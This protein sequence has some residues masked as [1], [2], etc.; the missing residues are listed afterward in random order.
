[1]SAL[2]REWKFCGLIPFEKS[3]M[4]IVLSK[5]L[6]AKKF[7]LLQVSVIW[8]KELAGIVLEQAYRCITFFQK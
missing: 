5:I 2:E 7:A 4:L 1:V 8:K 3:F 6:Y